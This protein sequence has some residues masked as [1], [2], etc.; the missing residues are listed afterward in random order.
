MTKSILKGVLIASA[1]TLLSFDLPSG[2]FKAGSMP[3]SYEMGIDKGKGPEGK[4]AATIKSID[5][6]IKGFGT[7]MQQ[8]MPTKYLG[9]K[10]RMAGYMKSE[11]VRDWAG[12]WLRVDQEGSNK[13]LSFDNMGDRPVKGTTDWKK[14]EIVLDVPAN[15]S[16]I[17]YGALLDGV[18]QIW[19]ANVSFEIVDNTIKSTGSA[20][21]QPA[22]VEEPT[23]LDFSK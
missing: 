3:G 6:H 19:F 2:W 16:L 7:L 23:N 5:E 14:Y 11:G 9:K 20:K 18:G 13:P 21:G 17:A 12:F 1:I 22:T 10:I 4:N 8:S 15:A